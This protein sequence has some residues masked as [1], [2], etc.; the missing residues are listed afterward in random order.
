MNVFFIDADFEDAAAGR[1][2]LHGTDALFEF[3]ELHR[4]TDGFRL[5]VSSRAIFDGDFRFHL[6]R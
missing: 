1:H 4:Q 2:Q 6:P 5:V 3:E